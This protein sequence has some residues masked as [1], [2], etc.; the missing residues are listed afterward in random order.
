[1]LSEKRT[2]LSVKKRDKRLKSM[3][4]HYVGDYTD[5][6][7]F[8]GSVLFTL[9]SVA[10]I[11]LVFIGQGLGRSHV[12]QAI[13]ELQ[14]VIGATS[15]TISSAVM[16]L[17][18]KRY[19]FTKLSDGNGIHSQRIV[20]YN[21]ASIT[22]LLGGI[23]QFRFEV[24][25]L[26]LLVVWGLGF[27]TGLSA[28]YVVKFG[29]GMSTT[30]YRIPAGSLDAR[31]NTTTLISQTSSFFDLILT[32]GQMD[33]PLGFLG[34]LGVIDVVGGVTTAGKP[35]GRIIYPTVD[36]F[37]DFKPDYTASA[38]LNGFQIA[39]HNVSSEPDMDPS[40]TLN[41]ADIWFI[42]ADTQSFTLIIGWP[43]G[44]YTM[45]FTPTGGYRT[46]SVCSEDDTI[47]CD[48]GYFT[49]Y[50]ATA[51]EMNGRLS[52]QANHT[53]FIGSRGNSPLTMSNDQWAMVMMDVIC[54]ARL[55]GGDL[56]VL[57]FGVVVNSIEDSTVA[58][59]EL[60]TS[61]LGSII[62]S[63]T[64]AN[65]DPNGPLT[66]ASTVQDPYSVLIPDYGVWVLISNTVISIIMLIMAWKF[67]KGSQLHP[68][69]LNSTRILLD[70]SGN[71]DFCLFNES[72]GST[73]DAL[74]D[75]CLQV[76]HNK[77]INLE[78]LTPP[79]HESLE[80]IS[81]LSSCSSPSRHPPSHPSSDHI[82]SRSSSPLLTQPNPQAQ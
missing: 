33:T 37:D 79:P 56:S 32:A 16:V 29:P 76:I 75:S 24:L 54:N 69:F 60:W 13:L 40:C 26:A 63:Y 11:I 25:S 19:L 51:V 78:V 9:A 61:V 15:L 42:N 12:P 46:Y 50:T 55:A 38:V 21:N 81:L 17:V 71:G 70:A 39:V 22:S 31:F 68:D 73:M 72:L 45:D 48:P 80:S 7:I 65:K 23:V 34:E 1:M 58:T 36:P 43:M 5:T 10:L 82:V 18:G 67:G 66:A 35:M 27:A 2:L 30:L 47:S 74:G 14:R 41:Q 28:N 4:N 6:F 53:S 3:R 49:Q 44:G 52:R 64:V 20:L 8:C 77:D 57:D 62:G 59:D